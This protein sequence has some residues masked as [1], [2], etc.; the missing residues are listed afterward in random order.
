MKGPDLNLGTANRMAEPGAAAHPSK[1][2]FNNLLVLPPW[3]PE[4]VKM[5][6]H[7]CGRIGCMRITCFVGSQTERLLQGQRQAWVFIHHLGK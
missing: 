5:P 3:I 6:L 4:A 1:Q 2:L 7:V